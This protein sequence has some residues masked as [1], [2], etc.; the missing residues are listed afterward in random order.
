MSLRSLPLL[1]VTNEEMYAVVESLEFNTH[2]GTFDMS[3]QY[4]DNLNRD[5]DIEVE[6]NN[7]D[8]NDDR[9]ILRLS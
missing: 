8:D 4:Q 1:E 7:E 3:I 2:V 9:A 6:R 5:D